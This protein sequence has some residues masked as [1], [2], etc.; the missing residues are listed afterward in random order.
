M[1]SSSQI[2]TNKPTSSFFYR[3]ETETSLYNLNS[4]WRGKCTGLEAASETHLAT[5][6]G[7]DWA[8]NADVVCLYHADDDDDDD[9]IWADRV[10]RWRWR[11]GGVFWMKRLLKGWC[12][13]QDGPVYN[14]FGFM[15]DCAVDSKK[16]WNAL[17]AGPFCV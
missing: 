2:T 4:R 14:H 3:P 15:Q 6:T 13:T 11:D 5:A 9:D 8:V 7:C 17:Y 16:Y 12:Y 10:L 1:Q